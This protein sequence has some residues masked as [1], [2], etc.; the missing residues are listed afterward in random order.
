M[1]SHSVT[2]LAVV[3]SRLYT[4]PKQELDLA[5]PGGCKA[6]LTYAM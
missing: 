3:K 5:T 1:G 6:E 4:Q 2:C